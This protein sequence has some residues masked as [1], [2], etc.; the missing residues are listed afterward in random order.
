MT[1]S[2]RRIDRRNAMTRTRTETNA[3]ADAQFPAFK[4][5]VDLKTPANIDFR[6]SRRTQPACATPRDHATPHRANI[7]ASPATAQP[8]H[9]SPDCCI[10]ISNA[11][12]AAQTAGRPAPD[13]PRG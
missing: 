13:N 8:A 5:A 10:G 12:F 6:I 2:K 9:S 1:T 4:Q 7:C 3:R 11:S